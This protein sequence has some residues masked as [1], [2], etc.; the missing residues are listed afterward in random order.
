MIKTIGLKTMKLTIQ[1]I[2]EDL[3]AIET[4]CRQFEKKYNLHSEFFF[5]AY[6]NGRLEDDGN[7]D[8]A[9]WAGFY[10]S[11]LDREQRSDFHKF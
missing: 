3:H 1:D 5:D 9:E 11:K 6:M 4:H 2:L 7:P 8:F 10:K